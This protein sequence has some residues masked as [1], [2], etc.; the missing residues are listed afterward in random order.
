M[1]LNIGSGPRRRNGYISV[2]RYAKGVDRQ[3]DAA[4]LPFPSGSA[5]EIL[6]SH[7]IE[8]LLPA[9]QDAALKEWYRVLKLGGRLVIRCPN[10]NLRVRQYLAAP[11]EQRGPGLNSIFGLRTEPGQIHYDGFTIPRLE[12][13]LPRY[14]FRVLSCRHITSR[15]GRVKNGDI[16]CEAVKE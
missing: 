12:R 11:D 2:D 4:K 3:A 6:A 16:L 9:H 14:G 8:H 13:T 10:F 7:L 5:D 1:K 15:D